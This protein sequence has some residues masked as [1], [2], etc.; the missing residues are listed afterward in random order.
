MVPD[1]VVAAHL[2]KARDLLGSKF[3]LQADTLYL[4]FI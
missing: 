4:R 1:C 2:P 3:S